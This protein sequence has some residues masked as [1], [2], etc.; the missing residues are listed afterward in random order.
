MK[1]MCFYTNKPIAAMH[2][3]TEDDL[4]KSTA[5]ISLF[6]EKLDQIVFERKSESFIL[7]VCRDG[8]IKIHAPEI[9]ADHHIDSTKTFAAS[10]A[11]ERK[12]ERYLNFLNA[13]YVIL[14]SSTL[15]FKWDGNKSIDIVD[16]SEI[17]RNDAFQMNKSDRY[18]IFESV[19]HTGI[20]RSN[21]YRSSYSLHHPI[22]F[23]TLGLNK[24]ILDDTAKQFEY[25]SGNNEIIQ[26]LSELAK[27]LSEF[28]QFNN[29]SSLIMAWFG[30]EKIINKMWNTLKN[31][32]L[33]EDRR[34][35]ILDSNKD[36][37]GRH[38]KICK[39]TIAHKINGLYATEKLDSR[40][41]DE[42]RLCR[43]ERNDIAHN[44]I[45]SIESD[46]AITANRLLIK[47]INVNYN[48]N[49]SASF[50]VST[51]AI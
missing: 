31:T 34:E 50:N 21:T 32:S 43:K 7:Q 5:D 10:F 3:I 29:S 49:I 9:E 23:S 18:S 30:I 11:P 51:T 20:A 16:F 27:S 38:I 36:S 14:Y 2:P 4:P 40:D 1:F 39:Y 25:I 42:L 12:W 33:F 24:E 48:L 41:Y 22:L 26:I 47:L 8:L 13:F 19:Y 15:N 35:I 37:S 6:H 45:T 44:N 17:T 46:T 28:K